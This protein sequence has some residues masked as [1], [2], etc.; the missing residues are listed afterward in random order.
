MLPPSTCFRHTPCMVI[1]IFLHESAISARSLAVIQ[2]I[3][4]RQTNRFDLV[5]FFPFH[6]LFRYMSYTASLLLT[7]LIDLR[8]TGRSMSQPGCVCLV[9]RRAFSRLLSHPLCVDHVL[10]RTCLFPYNTL[11]PATR[12]QEKY[13]NDLL[14]VRMLRRRLAT[15][16]AL[17]T[18]TED[19]TI[20][21]LC[22]TSLVIRM[23]SLNTPPYFAR[24]T[25][26]VLHPSSF[27]L[28]IRPAVVDTLSP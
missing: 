6:L 25:P 10:A 16:H 18:S 24:Y 4:V 20:S 28:F 7:M 12:L 9:V 13:A 11:F 19:N 8:L 21:V 5:L 2:L 27:L 1:F 14:I 22:T 3:Y 17:S 15:W 26:P 23:C